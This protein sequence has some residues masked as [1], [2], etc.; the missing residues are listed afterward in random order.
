MSGKT[1]FKRFAIGFGSV[2]I[3]LILSFWI[4]L[5]TLSTYGANAAEKRASY[6]GDELLPNPSVVWTHAE[7]IQAKPDVVWQWIAQ[8]GDTHGAFYSYTFIENMIGG[9]DLYQNADSIHPEWQDPQPGEMIISPIMGI[10]EVKKGEHFFGTSIIPDLGWTWLW[11]VVPEGDQA[12]RLQI[13]MRIQVPGQTTNS[14]IVNTV[15]LSGFVM[16]KGMMDG[17][18]NRAEGRIPAG[19]EQTLGIIVWMV[20]LIAG[21]ICAVLF[22]NRPEWKISLATGLA[23]VITLV[24]FTFVQQAMA[25]RILIDLLLI[26][27]TI[28]SIKTRNSQE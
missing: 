27:G 7:T 26:A 24:I 12:T 10:K 1:K 8:M 16:E 28:V 14:A 15:A 25:I 13:R 20:A 11:Q 9:S 19:Y 23:A 4:A 17:L 21:I 18:R 2:A 22:I 3:L 5:S 6:Y